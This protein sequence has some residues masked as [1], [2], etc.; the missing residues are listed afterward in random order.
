MNGFK[1]FTWLTG[2]LMGAV[3]SLGP[4]SA[5]ATPGFALHVTTGQT[6]TSTATTQ[7]PAPTAAPTPAPTEAPTPDTATVEGASIA[8]PNAE[9]GAAATAEGEGELVDEVD[10]STDAAD[11]QDTA[12]GATPTL[13]ADG[14]PKK[15]R[16]AGL[17]RSKSGQRNL[18]L[19]NEPS[20]A[21]PWR[22]RGN[23]SVSLGQGAFVSDSFAAAPAV[24]YSGTVSGSY[25][26]NSLLN[27]GARIDFFQQVT[28]TNQDGGAIPQQFFFRE[29]RLFG[30][31]FNLADLPG[32][33][34]L[35][36]SGT[37]FLPVDEVS[38][39][40]ERL[41]GLGAGLTLRRD[42]DHV[43]PGTIQLSLFSSFRENFGPR[44][45][46]VDANKGASM[47]RLCG[48]G[49]F[50]G[51]GPANTARQFALGLSG[52]YA[53]LDHFA[54]SMTLQWI[55]QFLWDITTGDLPPNV[56]A[57]LDGRP[58]QSSPNAKAT[59]GINNITFANID[60]SYMYNAN[61]S[62]SLGVSTFQDP[63][64]WSKSGGWAPRFPF[65]DFLEPAYNNTTFYTSVSVL[66]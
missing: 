44:Q 18:A 29:L 13:G 55:G 32:G 52:N 9:A 26:L 21:R 1:R 36:A 64:V 38:R 57:T 66:Y 8:T 3:V 25:K 2:A 42:F 60:F 35:D 30:N 5:S 34:H 49:E 65:F 56:V 51:A 20:A 28:I 45:Q 22:I 6:A 43:G 19:E 62:F 58:L 7:A 27:V 48:N 4:A 33:I 10:S 37:L 50:C 54:F 63:L 59:A 14:K 40:A 23:L 16:F 61:L 11:A 12:P 53:F 46:S 41:F 39:T 47:F 31:S 15:A 17:N 24:Q